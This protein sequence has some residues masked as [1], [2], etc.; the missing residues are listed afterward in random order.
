MKQLNRSITSFILL[1]I[2]IVTIISGCNQSSQK[3]SSKDAADAIYFGGDIITMEGDS[4]KYAE[5]VAVKNGKIIFVGKKA[6]A[7]K[8]KG[9]ST[10]MNDLK[11]KDNAARI[12][13]CAQSLYKFIA[14]G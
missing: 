9:D 10:K 3:T 14:G 11:G 4:A 7:E 12:Y 5:A 13:G 6:D 1:L 2:L 8:L